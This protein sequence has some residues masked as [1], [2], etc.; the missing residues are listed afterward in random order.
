MKFVP[1]PNVQSRR[2]RKALPR[3]GLRLALVLAVIALGVALRFLWLAQDD[4]IAPRVTESQQVGVSLAT[5]GRFAD[6]FPPGSGPTAHLTPVMPGI[7]ATVYRTFGVETVASEYVLAG[8]A[9]GLGALAMLLAYLI[10]RELGAPRFARIGAL[11]FVALAPIQFALEA[12]ELRVWESPL[13]LS[14]CLAILLAVLRLERRERIGFGV[15]AA[16][17]LAVALLFFTSPVMGLAGAGVYGLLLLRRARFIEMIGAGALLAS[18]LVAVHLPWAL[19]N[20]R[21]M[22]EMIWTRSNFGLELA[23]SNHPAAVDPKD[24]KAVYIARLHEIHPFADP[25]GY[26]K[27][28]EAGGELAYFKALGD[29]T[30]AW[31]ASNPGDA[32]RIWARHLGEYYFPP[33]WFWHTW[34][35]GGPGMELRQ[36]LIWAIAALA[37]GSLPFLSR[38]DPRYLYVACV[39]FVPA[40]PYI[41]V[42]P[43]LRYRYLISTVMVFLAADGSIRLFTGLRR[44]WKA[45]RA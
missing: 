27:M 29:E 4:R 37:L 28:V 44:R 31:I 19:R 41:I 35:T 22:G 13:A 36:A 7:I 1:R 23:L 20:E 16:L 26:R 42:Q 40:L 8:I 2:P 43:I 32:A 10:F 15:Y 14:G 18:A 17:A 34:G 12:S 25:I 33:M 30:R 9:I 39:V 11:L 24:G 38:R 5:T 3:K 45:R 6:T 21:A